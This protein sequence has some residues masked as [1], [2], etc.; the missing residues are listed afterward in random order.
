MRSET[1]LLPVWPELVYIILHCRVVVSLTRTTLDRLRLSLV[2]PMSVYITTV[3]NLETDC[4]S[5]DNAESS[6]NPISQRRRRGPS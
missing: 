5:S 3:Q 6:C 1:E 4:T 2:Q